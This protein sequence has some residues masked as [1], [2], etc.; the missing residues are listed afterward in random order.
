MAIK[1]K[2]LISQKIISND[3][4]SIIFIDKKDF[5]KLSSTVQEFLLKLPDE[6]TS[7]RLRDNLLHALHYLQQYY[8]ILQVRDRAAVAD[9]VQWTIDHSLSP[10]TPFR[11]ASDK[12]EW[13]WISVDSQKVRQSFSLKAFS[14]DSLKT[15]PN[16][17]V[18]ICDGDMNTIKNIVKQESISV[19]STD[20]FMRDCIAYAIQYDQIEILKFLIQ[21]GAKINNIASG[22]HTNFYGFA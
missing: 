22:K 14:A 4:L 2:G 7:S 17:I 18:A 10:L 9:S 5:Q 6:E 1:R 16:I 15:L 13:E 8:R 19:N 20:M 11:E 12:F 21:N 3:G